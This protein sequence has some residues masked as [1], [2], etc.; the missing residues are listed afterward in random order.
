[1]YCRWHVFRRFQIK[2]RGSVLPSWHSSVLVILRC[3]TKFH[4]IVYQYLLFKPLPTCKPCKT[5]FLLKSR[6]IQSWSNQKIWDS[7][8]SPGI[9]LQMN[10]Q[11]LPTYC[12]ENGFSL[13]LLD[14]ALSSHFT[15]RL[16]HSDIKRAHA[17]LL[18]FSD[19]VSLL[20]P[21]NRII[22]HRFGR[23]A[24]RL[25]MPSN[26]YCKCFG[27]EEE[28]VFRLMWYCPALVGKRRKSLTLSKRTG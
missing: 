9:V 24:V 5:G 11:G 21:I 15:C 8:I 10:W 1:M 19:V 25:G 27:S 23:L 6:I 7:R 12:R 16:S 18:D 20:S 26:V 3:S 22:C 2:F 13:P 4:F 17:G 14:W 28:T